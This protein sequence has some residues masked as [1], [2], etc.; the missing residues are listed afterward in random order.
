MFYAAFPPEINSGRMYTGPG[1]GP[2][3]AAAAAWDA[4]A[5][6]LQSTAAAFS[7]VIASLTS[8]PWIGPSSLAM[9]AA[10]APYVT[11]MGATAAQ[12][13]QAATQA[14]AA[15][16]AYE[17]AF[18]AHVPPVEIAANRAQLAMLVATN[19]FGQNTAAIAAAESQY[20]EMWAQDAT[21]MD[22]YAS[23]S[24]AASEVTPFAEPPQV[25]NAAGLAS[26][27]AVVGQA[28]AASPAATVQDLLATGPIS[29]LLQGSGVVD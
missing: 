20:A 2:L 27:A 17:T 11:W 5:A 3:L 18:A 25:V 21:A 22:G 14:T 6:E 1:S 26:Q 29:W 4:V 9:A 28:A 19:L 8:G 15:A 16:T 23:S 13:A 24:A 7:S 12:A 10:V